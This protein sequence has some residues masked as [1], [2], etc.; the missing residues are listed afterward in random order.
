LITVRGPGY[1]A[2]VGGGMRRRRTTWLLAAGLAV[3]LTACGGGDSGGGGE[4]AVTSPPGPNDGLPCAAVTAEEASAAWGTELT[5]PER[6]LDS[7]FLCEYH[8]AERQIVLRLSVGDSSATALEYAAEPPGGTRQEVPDLGSF[9]Y[10]DVDPDGFFGDTAELAISIPQ[11]ET[12][13]YLFLTTAR[14]APEED[15]ARLR[16]LAETAVARLADPVDGYQVDDVG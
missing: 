13:F 2:R 8:D 1:G 15:L 6:L 9:A 16:G 10:F 4:T 14:T 11:D 7:D 3:L 5:V 12:L